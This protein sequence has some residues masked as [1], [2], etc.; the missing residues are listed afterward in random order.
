MTLVQST[1]SN[2]GSENSLKFLV[3]SIL[4]KIL[5]AYSVKDQKFQ[6]SAIS[7]VQSGCFQIKS[8]DIFGSGGLSMRKLAVQI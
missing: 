2:K 5:S 1:W 4:C 3:Q 8:V 7:V 6:F